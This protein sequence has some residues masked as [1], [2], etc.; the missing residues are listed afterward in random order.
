MWKEW[1]LTHW[2]RIDAQELEESRRQGILRMLWEDCVKG[3]MERL[4]EDRRGCSVLIK[5]ILR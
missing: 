2:Q 3:G 5:N 1:Q 4:G